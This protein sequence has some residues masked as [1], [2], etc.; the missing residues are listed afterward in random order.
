[1]DGKDRVLVWPD[2]TFHRC[3]KAEPDAVE[4]AIAANGEDYINLY[5]P[6]ELGDDALAGQIHDDIK[7]GV[8]HV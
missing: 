6:E 3:D 4:Q 5:F 1:M 7:A 8:Y 2:E